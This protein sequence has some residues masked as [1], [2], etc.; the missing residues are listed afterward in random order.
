MT[1][2][3]RNKIKTLKSAEVA[4]EK[5]DLFTPCFNLITKIFKVFLPPQNS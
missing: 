5:T 2:F 3:D 1:L 4:G